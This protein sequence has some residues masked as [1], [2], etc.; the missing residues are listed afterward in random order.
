M[1][2]RHFEYVGNGSDKFWEVTYPDS[3]VDRG[4]RTWSVRWG[5]R[6][7]S[8]QQKHFTEGNQDAASLAAIDKIRE[9]RHKGYREV[10]IRR[11]G[12]EPG[13][14][15]RPIMRMPVVTKTV[16]TPNITGGET[17]GQ[18]KKRRIELL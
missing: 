8:G 15:A 11:D 18:P 12:P 5:R 6:G 16:E 13:A 2:T 9:K 10:V 7:T 14:R 17:L 1:I 3:S 4:V